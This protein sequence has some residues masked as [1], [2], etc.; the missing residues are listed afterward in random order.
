MRQGLQGPNEDQSRGW[1]PVGELRRGGAGREA[2]CVWKGGDPVHRW[3]GI[4]LYLPGNP[5]AQW[6]R[7]APFLLLE[8]S[9]CSLWE[10]GNPG[11]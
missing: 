1:G 10:T 3:Q 7:I 9:I 11:G 8:N 2:I 5:A 6:E 4:S